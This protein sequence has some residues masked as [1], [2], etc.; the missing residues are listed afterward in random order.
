MTAFPAFLII[1]CKPTLKV[2]ADYDRTADFS[3]YKTFGMYFM[4]T[5]NNVNQLNEQRVWNSI[6]SEMI[7]KGYKEDSNNPDLVVN[8][9][10]VLKNKK[11]ISAT[12]TSYGYGGI[13]R[14]YSYWGAPGYATV[15][16][17]DYK[18]GS[19]VIDVVDTR[20]KRLVW[21]GAANAE[22]E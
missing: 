16:A 22:F 5:S 10:T 4:L 17:T 14:P 11:Y 15:R 21:E 8:V 3:A 1:S 6:R 7:K 9:A 20:T 13:H 12:A 2:T 19:L 18:E